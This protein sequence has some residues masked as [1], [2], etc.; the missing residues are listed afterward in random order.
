MSD[1]DPQISIKPES[2]TRLVSSNEGHSASLYTSVTP[3][4]GIIVVECSPIL[5][6]S[7]RVPVLYIP[8]DDVKPLFLKASSHETY[9]PYKGTASHF[10]LDVGDGQC[11]QEP[12]AWSY[13]TPYDAVSQIAGHISF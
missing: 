6:V 4:E 5:Q 7:T 13:Q 11:S 12:I 2:N 9:C 8:A 1:F 10:D 3:C